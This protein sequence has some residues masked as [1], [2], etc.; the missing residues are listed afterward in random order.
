VGGREGVS[1]RV[2]EW[3]RGEGVQRQGLSHCLSL[4]YTAS[5]ATTASHTSSLSRTTTSGRVYTHVYPPVWLMSMY[6]CLMLC[7]YLT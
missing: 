4:H 2:S 7:V 3:V 1:E 5:L 6:P